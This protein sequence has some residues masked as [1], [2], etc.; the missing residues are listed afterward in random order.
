MIREEKIRGVITRT[1]ARWA[2]HG[3]KHSKYFIN[4]EKRHYTEKN[5]P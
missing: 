2:T 1:R 4:L 5:I 3:E